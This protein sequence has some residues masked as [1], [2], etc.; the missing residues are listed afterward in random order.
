MAFFDK[1]GNMAKNISD[2]TGDAIEVTKLQA[3]IGNER[4]A[5]AEQM[6]KLGEYYYIKHNKG[7][8]LEESALEFCKVI[9]EHWKQI[10]EAQAKIDKIKSDNETQKTAS[11][12][13]APQ[14][15]PQ[16]PAAEQFQ[17]APEAPAAPQA[18][19]CTACG[20]KLDEGVKFCGSCGAKVP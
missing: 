1:V 13:S 17:A 7:E 8:Q 16:A 19:F 12:A 15:A 10:T 5:M 18:H 9:D 6:R 4:N 3:K 14:M 11:G 2:R 20:A